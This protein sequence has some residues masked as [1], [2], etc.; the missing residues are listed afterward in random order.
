M[1]RTALLAI[2][3]RLIALRGSPVVQAAASSAHD[4]L[5]A[6]LAVA[7]STAA[8][9]PSLSSSAADEGTAVPATAAA[10]EAGRLAGRAHVAEAGRSDAHAMGDRAGQ[11][12][13]ADAATLLRSDNEDSRPHSQVL[14]QSCAFVFIVEQ[15]CS[16]VLPLSLW[17]VGRTAFHHLNRCGCSILRLSAYCG[18]HAGVP[19]RQRRACSEPCCKAAAAAIAVQGAC[20]GVSY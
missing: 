8:A 17:R 20:H 15:V 11:E 14:W 13:I 1:I 19:V 10:D 3:D 2:M 18:H 6:G 12:G 4:E 9:E 16:R 5:S 7:T